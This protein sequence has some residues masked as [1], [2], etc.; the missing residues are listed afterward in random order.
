MGKMMEREEVKVLNTD[1][2]VSDD[3]FSA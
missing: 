2:D 1:E 3:Q